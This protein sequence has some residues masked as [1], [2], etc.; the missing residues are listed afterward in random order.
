[1][2]KKIILIFLVVCFAF[3]VLFISVFRAAEVRYEFASNSKPSESIEKRLIID[4]QLASPGK[5]LPDSPFWLLKAAR[6]RVWLLSTRNPSRVAELYLL[7]A[8]KRLGASKILF[9]NQKPEVALST[10]T[11]AEKYLESAGNK[12]KENRREGIDTT[13]F[14]QRLASAALK[15][16][17]VIQEIYGFAPEEA[18]PQIVKIQSYPVSV[19]N[20]ARDALLEKGIT[21]PQNPFKW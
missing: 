17:E 13:E 14:L 3:G 5:I 2:G 20:E 10:L 9:Q 4:Y 6:D 15:H 19:Y 8:D 21:P 18:R 11:K 16:Y 1:M 7:F 12:E